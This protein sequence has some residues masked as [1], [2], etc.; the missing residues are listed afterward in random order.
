MDK[1]SRRCTSADQAVSA[2]N[3]EGLSPFSP[4]RFLP[5]LPPFTLAHA[6]ATGGR[7]APAHDRVPCSA[8]VP[9]I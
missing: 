2:V 4:P 7:C 8:A 9:Q 3:F 5:A 1:S 6:T